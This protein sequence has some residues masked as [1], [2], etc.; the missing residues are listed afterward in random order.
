MEFRYAV[1]KHCTGYQENYWIYDILGANIYTTQHNLNKNP[2][3]IK[4]LKLS[5]LPKYETIPLLPWIFLLHSSA[6]H[7]CSLLA[8]QIPKEHGDPSDLE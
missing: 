3:Y 2:N 5:D 8:E 1:E 4:N 6:P 7:L